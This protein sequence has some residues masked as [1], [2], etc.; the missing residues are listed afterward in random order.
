[1]SELEFD[2]R[3]DDPP[4]FRA[5]AVLNDAAFEVLLVPRDLRALRSHS[6][7][8][9]RWVSGGDQRRGILVLVEP[10]I[11]EDRIMGEWQGLHSILK[12]RVC[13]ALSLVLRRE[14]A[15]CRVIGQLLSS[16]E[17][18]SLDEV[19]RHARI[20]AFS[21]PRRRAEA[22]FDVLRVLLIH[23]I[24]ESGPLTSKRLSEESGFSYPTIAKALE[25]LAPYLHRHSDRRVELRSFPKDAWLRLI[26]QPERVRP[27]YA[28]TDRSGS[29][30]SPEALL[31]R[32][33][34]LRRP[35]I[36]VAGVL[37]ARHYFPGLDLIGT[38]R[39]DLVLHSHRLGGE[40][41][42]VRRL[43][44]ALKPAKHGEPIRLAIHVLH[45]PAS[46]FEKDEQGGRYADEVECLLDLHD[47]RLEAQALEFLQRL[48]P[49]EKS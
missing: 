28:Y 35:D 6:L 19:V 22:F 48:T 49:N 12:S 4:G 9:A 34:E 43:D 47:V 2:V 38:P 1:M 20:H 27:A 5:D 41:D 40:R 23:W 36:A 29:P 39:L 37:G 15:P 7:D 45:R 3:F 32:L 33:C 30:R 42:I 21:K 13:R 25:R 31:G 10:F 46:F 16:A 14:D 24:R 18:A 11:S 44:P 17:E 8:I 26:A